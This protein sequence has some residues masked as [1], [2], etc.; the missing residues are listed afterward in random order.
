MIYSQRAEPV[1][2]AELS[3]S[4]GLVLVLDGRVGD[5]RWRAR[6]EIA[7]LGRTQSER[8]RRLALTGGFRLPRRELSFGQAAAS[9]QL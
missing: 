2:T 7:P 4:C 1:K 9:T 6:L 3:K 8:H 5:R